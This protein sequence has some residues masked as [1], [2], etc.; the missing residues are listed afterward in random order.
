MAGPSTVAAAPPLAAAIEAALLEDMPTMYIVECGEAVW[1][2]A[3]FE[4]MSEAG[5]C[6]YL[7]DVFKQDLDGHALLVDGGWTA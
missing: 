2:N 4:N 1:A 5:T 7:A 3:G 6:A